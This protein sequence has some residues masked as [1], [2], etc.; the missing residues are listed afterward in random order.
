MASKFAFSTGHRIIDE[1]R[2]SL[3]PAM[4]EAL[5]CTENWLQSKLFANLVYNLQE[6]I[7]EQM[8]HMELQECNVFN[9][10]S[11]IKYIIY[12]KCIITLYRISTCSHVLELLIFFGFYRVY[13]IASFDSGSGE[14]RHWCYGCLKGNF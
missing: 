6:V 8:F 4:V 12:L 5:I 14:R 9:F 10:L 13:K 11:Y 7:K 3:T 2:S 1:S